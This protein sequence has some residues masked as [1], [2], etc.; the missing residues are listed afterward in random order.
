MQHP[1]DLGL[2]ELGPISQARSA[3]EAFAGALAN[4][5]HSVPALRPFT[6][7]ELEPL[8]RLEMIE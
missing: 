6:L 4:G 2:L 8:F 5:E 3:K 7:G 1:A